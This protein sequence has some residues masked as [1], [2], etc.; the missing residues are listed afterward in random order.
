MRKDALKLLMA[1]S[2]IEGFV[3]SQTGLKRPEGIGDDL[4]EASDLCLKI[5]ERCK[6]R[7]IGISGG[8]VRVNGSHAPIPAPTKYVKTEA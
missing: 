1:I 2:R 6:M 4:T 5:L 8:L 7:G 3:I